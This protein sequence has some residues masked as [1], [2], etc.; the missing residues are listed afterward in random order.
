M[1]NC[2]LGASPQSAEEIVKRATPPRKVFFRPTKS[3][4]RPASI[5][6]P[7]KVIR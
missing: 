6:N 4:K 7:P 3:A 2:L 5:R 1:S